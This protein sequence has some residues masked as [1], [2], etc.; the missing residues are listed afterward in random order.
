MTVK[1]GLQSIKGIYIYIMK[2]KN[3]KLVQ[4]VGVNDADYVVQKMEEVGCIDG[5]RK[6]KFVWICPYYKVWKNMID[7]CYSLKIQ[8]KSPTYKGCT[9]SEDWLTFSN[10]K[11]WMMAQDWKDKQLDKD[12]IIEGNKTYSADACVFVTQMV[13]LF[14]LYRGNDRG[15]W[16]VGVSWHKGEGKFQAHCRNPFT[17]K[18]EYLGLFNCEHEAHEAWLKR[19]LE[20]AREL[21]AIQTDQR[22]AK[23]LISRYSNY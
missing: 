6:R 13:N 9:V 15:E 5:K 22:V 23:A 2:L 18:Q 12:L 14:T 20:L 4:G 8:E 1:G 3:K 19:K 21:A 10:F 17:K 7:R 16:L 11:G